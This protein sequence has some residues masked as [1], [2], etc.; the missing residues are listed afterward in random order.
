MGLARGGL[1][2]APG[3]AGAAPAAL[4]AFASGIEEWADRFPA[5][6]SAPPLAPDAA[7][8]EVLRVAAGEQ[9]L[10]LGVDD[11]QWLDAQSLSTLHTLARDLIRLPI[12]VKT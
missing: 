1:L 9:P 12:R 7:L 10:V 6:R 11:A 4:A 8:T 2:A 5:A 3:I